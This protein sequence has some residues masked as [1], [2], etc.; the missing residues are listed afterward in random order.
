MLTLHAKHL[1][2]IGGR[3]YENGKCGDDGSQLRTAIVV[4]AIP[5]C[6]IDRRATCATANGTAS[7]MA[8]A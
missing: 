1:P 3:Q 5:L 4:S 2:E 6:E 8:S 7:N